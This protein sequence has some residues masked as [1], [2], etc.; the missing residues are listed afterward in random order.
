[1]SSRFLQR[2]LEAVDVG[3]EI[4]WLVVVLSSGVLGILL[5]LYNVMLLILT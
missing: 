4:L 2:C 5:A 3:L 1:M